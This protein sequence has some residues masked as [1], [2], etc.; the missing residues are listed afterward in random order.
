LR[1]AQGMLNWTTWIANS[2][3]SLQ[4]LQYHHWFRDLLG[5]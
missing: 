2:A 1:I 3:Y 4:K 5:N